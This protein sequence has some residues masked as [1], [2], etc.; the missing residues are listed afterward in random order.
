MNG[1]VNVENCG[2][3]LTVDFN[4]EVQSNT[5]ISF[6]AANGTYVSCAAPTKTS[7]DSCIS[8]ETGVG[9]FGSPNFVGPWC[10]AN[11]IQHQKLLPAVPADNP[12]A[13][14][15]YDIT[16]Y[17][18]SNPRKQIGKTN[19]PF[20]VTGGQTGALDSALP[21]VFDHLGM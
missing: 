17:D 6:V 1:R 5:R 18:N 4:P 13:Q 9:A 3:I 19:G 16:I 2:G 15:S 20:Y 14:Y 7:G 11:I 10:V 8:V 12:A 21:S